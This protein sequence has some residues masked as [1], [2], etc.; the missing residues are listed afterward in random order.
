M[1]K[2]AFLPG[3]LLLALT[4]PSPAALL[5]YEGFNGYTNG[6]NLENLAANANTTGIALTGGATYG[7]GSASNQP[8]GLVITNSGGLSL[9]SL[10]T[11]GGAITFDSGTN[12]ASIGITSTTAG[13][14]LWGSYLAR[15]NSTS[16]TSAQGVDIRL[17]SSASSSATAAFF[18]SDA[19]SR[20]SAGTGPAVSYDNGMGAAA[21]GLTT[22]PAT[23]HILISRFTGLGGTTGGTATIWALN[24]DQFAAFVTAG[25]TEDFLANSA[26]VTATATSSQ[27]DS[28]ARVWNGMFFEIVTGGTTGTLDEFRY[29]ETLLD[30]TPIPEPASLSLLGAGSLLF[31]RRRRK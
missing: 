23:T 9:G 15:L 16:N 30:V 7:N 22:T 12:V 8:D 17:N 29:G 11:S 6:T 20:G 27:S 2:P 21:A 28:T 3:L 18:R 10:V 5:L 4:L 19:D 31:L 26:N 14:V 24:S 1:E 25:R 13:T